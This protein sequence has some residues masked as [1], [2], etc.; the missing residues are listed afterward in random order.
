MVKQ[1][2]GSQTHVGGLSP[3]VAASWAADRRDRE[4]E[5]S[6]GASGQA[7]LYTETLQGYTNI[8]LKQTAGNELLFCLFSGFKRHKVGPASS[9]IP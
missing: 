5:A 8:H 1:F 7:Y 4:R 9:A 3:R 2:I 6:G